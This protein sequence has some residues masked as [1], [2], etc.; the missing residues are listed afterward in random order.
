MAT[1]D[2]LPAEQRAIL[3]LVLQRHQSYDDLASMLGMPTPRVR[4]LAR[5]ALAELSPR[6]AARVD[7]DWRGQ[8]ADYLLGPADRP[9]GH[10]DPRAPEAL[11]AGAPLGA[12]AARLARPPLRRARPARDPGG[13]RRAP[14]R[15]RA[16]ARAG[17]GRRGR[18]RSGAARAAQP[19]PVGRRGGDRAPP[20]HRRRCRGRGG[21]SSS[22]CSSGPSASSP[23]TT[24]T[25]AATR[26]TRPAASR[27]PSASSCCARRAA[28]RAS[29]SR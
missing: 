3:E 2:Q 20:A 27:S 15:A 14:P 12:V 19:T 22:S 24:T 28:R 16:R 1:F 26:A 13:R 29:A 6:S 18:A 25:A 4:Q 7:M 5:E 21:R 10:G 17:A 9:G 8:V 11:R 23:A